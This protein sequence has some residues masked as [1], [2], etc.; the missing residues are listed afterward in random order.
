MP[1]L[2]RTFIVT[3]GVYAG[4]R[5]SLQPEKPIFQSENRYLAGSAPANPQDFSGDWPGKRFA[6]N[7]MIAL[8]VPETWVLRGRYICEI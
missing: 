3:S 7:M 2:F 8:E 1:Q 5:P 6:K 4:R